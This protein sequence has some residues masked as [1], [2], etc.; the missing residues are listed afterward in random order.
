MADCEHKVIL[1]VLDEW[2]CRDCAFPF[3]PQEMVTETYNPET[4]RW[5]KQHE[6]HPGDI[7]ASD[8]LCSSSL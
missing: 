1:K 7:D 2:I 5:E 8:S 4:G 6:T 3:E